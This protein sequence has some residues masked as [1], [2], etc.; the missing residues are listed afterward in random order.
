METSFTETPTTPARVALKWG[1]ISAVIGIAYNVVMILIDKFQDPS[2]GVVSGIF[3]FGVAILILVLAMRDFRTQNGGFLSFGQ[4]LSIGTL[5]SG[6]SGLIGG[7]FILV[8]TQFI[9]PSSQNRAMDKVREQWEAQGMDEAQMEQAE[10]FTG[11]LMSPGAQFL[12]A[13][14][15][16]VILGFIFSLVVAA[17]MKKDRP[18]FS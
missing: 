11:A 10:K 6:I 5:S 3:G 15:G 1:L 14:V 12:F 18:V 7:L 17:I 16:S 13:V 9:D 8:Y 4:G 2:M